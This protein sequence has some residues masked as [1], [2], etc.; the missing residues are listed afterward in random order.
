M[1]ENSGDATHAPSEET[2]TIEKHDT[3][4]TP[5]GALPNG[6][7]GRAGLNLMQFQMMQ[8]DKQ[9]AEQLDKAQH[10]QDSMQDG[11]MKDGMQQD[12]NGPAVGAPM[13]NPAAMHKNMQGLTSQQLE[14]LQRLRYA[15]L[16]NHGWGQGPASVPDPTGMQQAGGCPKCPDGAVGPDGMPANNQMQLAQFQNSNP[17]SQLFG[18]AHGKDATH[19]DGQGQA[20]Q[21]QDGAIINYLKL[22]IFVSY[23][24]KNRF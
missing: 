4:P 16:A 20:P 5:T 24:K 3:G 22:Q 6:M 2:V 23:V 8:H 9:L 13:Q 18:G 19:H 17:F 14:A 11:D 7:P 21:D 15:R 1:K 12:G 10:E